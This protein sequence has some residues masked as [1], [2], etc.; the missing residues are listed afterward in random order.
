MVESSSYIYY[1]L[2]MESRH[3]LGQLL[4]I[5]ISMTELS[6]VTPPESID[7]TTLIK[8]DGVIATTGY[9]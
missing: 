9:F 7:M 2:V 1:L 8:S 4:I 3:L 6:M 5:C